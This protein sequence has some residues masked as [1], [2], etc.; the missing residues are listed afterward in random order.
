MSSDALEAMVEGALYGAG[1]GAQQVGAGFEQD[2]R[3]LSRT[4]LCTPAERALLD[5]VL[6]DGAGSPGKLRPEL[7]DAVLLERLNPELFE[8][9]VLARMAFTAAQKEA[10]AA[11]EALTAAGFTGTRIEAMY[12]RVNAEVKARRE[13]GK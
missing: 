5:S 3:L 6:G 8:R 10:E 13:V 12:D 4:E 1:A 7:V 11:F 2:P 9:A